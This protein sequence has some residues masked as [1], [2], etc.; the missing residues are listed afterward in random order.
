MVIFLELWQKCMYLGTCFVVF[1]CLRYHFNLYLS[2]F[3]T[4]RILW[5]KYVRNVYSCCG[6]Y[7][8]LERFSE[9]TDRMFRSWMKGGSIPPR[10]FSGLNIGALISLIVGFNYYVLEVFF[11]VVSEWIFCVYVAGYQTG[12]YSFSYKYTWGVGPK[13][14]PSFAHPGSAVK[15]W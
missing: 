6:S 1:L 9:D 8:C 12:Q 14:C 5:S 13:N 10:F 3:W 2:C 15:F 4:D 11:F 7:L